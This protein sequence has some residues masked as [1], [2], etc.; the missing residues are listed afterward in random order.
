[1]STICCVHAGSASGGRYQWVLDAVCEA[2]EWTS[3]PLRF[4]SAVLCTPSI[5]I[6]KSSV[7]SSIKEFANGVSTVTSKDPG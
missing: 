2:V 4:E 6:D 5:A 7:R 1:M 3:Q